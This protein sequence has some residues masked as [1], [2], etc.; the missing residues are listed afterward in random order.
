MIVKL[1]CVAISGGCVNRQMAKTGKNKLTAS[2]EDY[3]EAILMLVRTGRVARVR[4]IAARIGVGMPAV[5]AALKSLSK[6]NLV[7]YDP[8]QVVTLTADGRAIAEDVSRRH[9]TLRRFL[10]EVLGLDK[11]LADANACR[12][13]HAVDNAVLESLVTLGEFLR[14]CPVASGRWPEYSKGLCDRGIAP[15]ACRKCINEVIANMDSDV[16]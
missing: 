3:M 15:M 10:I 14:N 1:K 12:M 5:S 6:R 8:Y 9:M 7:N 16:S 4:D 2:K 11:D 13:E